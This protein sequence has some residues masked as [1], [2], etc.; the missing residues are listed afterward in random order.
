MKLE[1]I[2]ARQ[3]GELVIENTKLKLLNAALNSELQ[4]LRASE[5]ELPLDRKET[6]HVGANGTH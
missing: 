6:A 2:I 3:I 4:K 5:P 1:D